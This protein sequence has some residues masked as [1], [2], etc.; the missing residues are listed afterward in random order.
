MSPSSHSPGKVSH[1]SSPSFSL[2]ER[3]GSRAK[4]RRRLHGLFLGPRSPSTV[5]FSKAKPWYLKA[6]PGGWLVGEPPQT[7]KQKPSA[8]G[9]SKGLGRTHSH[10]RGVGLWPLPRLWPLMP[11]KQSPGP[12]HR[13]AGC[14]SGRNLAGLR[15]PRGWLTHQSSSSSREREA[16]A[17]RG[18]KQ[19]GTGAD[20]PCPGGSKPHCPHPWPNSGFSPNPPPPPGAM[21]PN[22]S[23]GARSAGPWQQGRL[24]Q[25]MVGATASFLVNCYPL[26]TPVLLHASPLTQ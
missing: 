1:A 5:P 13:P 23:P 6:V 26:E 12:E 16:Q 2:P 4:W 10:C 17:C 14:D 15:L 22:G 11:L 21:G 20:A 25:V 18:R 7:P 24:G 8:Q 3:V 19:S 9:E